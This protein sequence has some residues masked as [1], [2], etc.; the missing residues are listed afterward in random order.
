MRITHIV[1]M[2]GAGSRKKL[3]EASRDEKRGVKCPSVA[4]SFFFF[5]F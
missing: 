5:G 3:T 2:D 4:E 1:K